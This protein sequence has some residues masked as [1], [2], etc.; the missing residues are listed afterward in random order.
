MSKKKLI[1]W[2][3]RVVENTSHAT[4]PTNS[5]YTSLNGIINRFQII[6]TPQLMNTIKI[7]EDIKIMLYSCQIYVYP[8]DFVSKCQQAVENSTVKSGNT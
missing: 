5:N 2:I 1:K 6:S 8:C 3:V 7:Q 4:T